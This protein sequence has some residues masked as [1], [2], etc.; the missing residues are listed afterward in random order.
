MYRT[1]VFPVALCGCETLFL[2]MG[3]EHRLGVLEYRV[4]RGVYGTKRKDVKG[5]WR[6]DSIKSSCKNCRH[7][8]VRR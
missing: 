3:Q 7:Q 2:T 5:G 1:A 4:L 8:K 6:E